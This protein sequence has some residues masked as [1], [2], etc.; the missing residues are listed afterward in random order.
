LRQRTFARA[1]RTADAASARLPASLL[2]RPAAALLTSSARARRNNKLPPQPGGIF[3]EAT[4]RS[5]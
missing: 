2:A 3:I 5:F 1:Q 4:E